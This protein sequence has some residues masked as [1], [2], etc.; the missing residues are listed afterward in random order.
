M[1]FPLDTLDA[2]LWPFIP[3]DLAKLMAAAV[4]LPAGWSLA[5]WPRKP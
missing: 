2:G 5:E 1:G 4:V 3:G